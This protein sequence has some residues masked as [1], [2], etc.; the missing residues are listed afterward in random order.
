MHQRIILLCLWVYPDVRLQ[1][2]LLLYVLD[3]V[4]L[5][6]V[7]NGNMVVE[8]SCILGING[9][10]IG[11]VEALPVRQRMEFICVRNDGASCILRRLRQQGRAHVLFFKN[12]T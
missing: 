12:K 11:E 9:C 8:P 1:V 6:V 2:Q 5:T 7:R 10:L 3:F 4:V